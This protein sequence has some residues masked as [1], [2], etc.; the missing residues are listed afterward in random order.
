MDKASN[1]LNRMRPILE[2]MERSIDS[3]RRDRLNSDDP[4]ADERPTSPQV[5]TKTPSDDAVIGAVT[6]RDERSEDEL[7]HPAQRMKARPKR[8][9]NEP[10]DTDTSGDHGYRSRAS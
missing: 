6:A 4:P 5:A 9:P 7:I 10:L 8:S 2:A 3:A 1:T